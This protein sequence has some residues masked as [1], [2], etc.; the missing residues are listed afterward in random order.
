MHNTLSRFTRNLLAGLALGGVLLAAATAQPA[1]ATAS[2][3][4]TEAAAPAAGVNPNGPPVGFTAPADPKA[5]D[6]NAERGKSQPGNN[7]PVWR[8]VRDSGSQPGITNL[9][10]AEM[11][12]LIQSFVQYPGS[13]FA[14]AGEAWRQVRNEWIIPYGGAL[15][16][17]TAAA[18][19]LF[20]WKQGP[21]GGHEPDTGRLIER[22]SYFERVAH[23]SMAISFVVLALSGLVLAFGKFFLLPILGGTLFGWLSYALKNVHN[24]AGPLFAVALVIFIVTYIRDN[25]PSKADLTWVLEGGGFFREKAAPSPRFNAGEKI[26]FW[27]GVI[28]LGLSIVGSGLV[29]NQLTPGVA[30]TRGNMQVAHLVHAVASLLMMAMVLGHIYLGSVGVKGA[31]QG[32]RTGYVDEAWAK[33]HHELWYDDIKAGRVPAQRSGAAAATGLA[34]MTPQG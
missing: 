32:M 9:P 31:Y 29:L 1:P 19:G 11:G 33:E 12:V 15:F 25:I 26:V 3:A 17:I 34:P 6:T 2:I 28:F 24:F 10:G 16:L 4:S 23:W 8:S 5:D 27:G 20:Y 14:S 18:I 13:R 22:F 30:Y 7:A 21:M